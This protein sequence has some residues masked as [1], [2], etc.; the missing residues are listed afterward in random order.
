MAESYIPFDLSDAPETTKPQVPAQRQ[1]RR[2]KVVDPITYGKGVTRPFRRNGAGD[3]NNASDISLV[4]ANVG[5]VL[6]TICSSGDTDGEIPWRPEFGSLM[7]LLR[8]RNLDEV[9]AELARVHVTDAINN[10]VTRVRVTDAL[11]T[12]DLDNTSLIIKVTYDVLG[13][14]RRSVAAASQSSTT[15]VPLG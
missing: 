10:W 8:Y 7:H 11:V 6:G 12:I 9:T 5:Q 4:R 15:V 1:S 3:F 14:N 2:R 13:S